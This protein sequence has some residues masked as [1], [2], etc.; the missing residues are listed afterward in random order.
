MRR[1]TKIS[2]FVLLPVAVVAVT[3]VGVFK[4]RHPDRPD[5]L[6][7]LKTA[8]YTNL[9][10]LGKGLF[11]E[12]GNADSKNHL[13]LTQNE[14]ALAA[15]ERALSSETEAFQNSERVRREFAGFA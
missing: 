14:S 12:A 2:L 10:G 13:F 6:D 8:A 9:L 11:G 15:A 5:F 1:N 4:A 3:S 7:P